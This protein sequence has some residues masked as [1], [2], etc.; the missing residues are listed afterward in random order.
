[1]TDEIDVLRTF[2]DETPGPSTDAWARARA[3]IAAA[4]SE[5]QTTV[6][7]PATGPGRRGF[8]NATGPGRRRRFTIAV[9]TG[10]AAAVA[11][12][13]AVLLPGS[14]ATAPR[15][16]PSIQTAAYVTRIEQALSQSGQASLVGYSRTLLPPGSSVVLT[17]DGLQVS[18][19]PGATPSPGLRTLVRWSYQG[20]DKISA[21][22]AV[23]RP[24]FDARLTSA[25]GGPAEAVIYGNATWWRAAPTG[26]QAPV[27]Q[28]CGKG[29]ELGAGGWPALIRF[30]LSCGA[31]LMHSRERVDGVDA[32]KLTG[33]RGLA[34]LW[35][36]PKTY[37][38][39]RA[40]FDLGQHPIQTDFRWLPPTSANVTHLSLQV[41]P[42]F[43]Q[44]RPPA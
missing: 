11:G 30:E 9:V 8:R 24:V 7:P 6:F 39:V 23:G 40:V 38:P 44:V 14:P 25:G 13:L 15:P 36:D 1:V 17:A 20:T 37:L 34:A 43:R 22:A 4:R 29:V 10:V 5:E 18:V 41:P 27:P 2:R 31:Y 33:N 21:F 32:L 26:T 16:T 28:T 42:G 12:L 35:I 3:A 19:S